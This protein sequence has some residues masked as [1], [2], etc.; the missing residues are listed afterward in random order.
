MAASDSK[1]DKKALVARFDLWRKALLDLTAKNSLINFKTERSIRAIGTSIADFSNALLK[2]PYKYVRFFPV[3]MPDTDTLRRFHLDANPDP[4]EWAEFLGINRSF[5]LPKTASASHLPE[6]LSDVDPDD[7]GSDDNWNGVSSNDM[8]PTGNTGSSKPQFATTSKARKYPDLLAE[9]QDEIAKGEYTDF[10]VLCSAHG[11]DIQ[12]LDRLVL[13]ERERNKNFAF[14]SA[15]DWSRKCKG[16]EG[17]F[18]FSLCAEDFPDNYRN[19]QDTCMLQTALYSSELG[20]KV[21]TLYRKGASAQQETGTQIVHLIVG[22]LEYTDAPQ[23]GKI[24]RAPLIS[25][26]AVISQEKKLGTYIYRFEFSSNSIQSNLSLKEYFDK[27]CGAILPEYEDDEDFNDYLDKIESCAKKIDPRWKVRRFISAGILT[28]TKIMLWKELQATPER[29]EE[30]IISGTPLELCFTPRTESEIGTEQRDYEFDKIPDVLK[31]LPLVDKADSSQE[32]ALF[33]VLENKSNLIIQGPPGTGKSQTITNLLALA[34]ERGMTVLFVAEKLAALQ[35][36]KTR[37][38]Q[39]GL[40]DFCLA[41]HSSGS[42]KTAV[43]HSIIDRVE[44]AEK[45]KLENYRNDINA[46]RKLYISKRDELNAYA[47]FI[48]ELWK[49]SGSTVHS[50]VGSY[51]ET[52][53]KL[54]KEFK[55]DPGISVKADDVTPDLRDEL[56]A[57]TDTFVDIYKSFA[58]SVTSVTSHP[59]YKV[60]GRFF[61]EE[62]DVR[63]AKATLKKWQDLVKQAKTA[64]SNF[65]ARY[66]VDLGG[67]DPKRSEFMKLHESLD[68]FKALPSDYMYSASSFLLRDGNAEKLGKF[69]E[70]Y[71]SVQKPLSKVTEYIGKANARKLLNGELDSIPSYFN[72][73]G[74][75]KP[76]EMTLDELSELRRKLKKTLDE[77]EDAKPFIEAIKK[78]LPDD[79]ASLIT[80]TP[81]GIGFLRRL[82]HDADAIPAKAGL[83][84]LEYAKPAALSSKVKEIEGEI[85]DYEKLQE[86]LGNLYYMREIPAPEEFKQMLS[87]AKQRNSMSLVS[88]MFHREYGKA[89]KSLKS[90]FKSESYCT[91]ENINKLLDYFER[92][93]ALPEKQALVAALKSLKQWHDKLTDDFGS[94][95]DMTRPAADFLSSKANADEFSGIADLKTNERLG[96]IAGLI[97]K[98]GDMVA[99]YDFLGN[100]DELLRDDFS[101]LKQYEKAIGAKVE[102]LETFF[103]KTNAPIQELWDCSDLAS[104]LMEKAREFKQMQTELSQMPGFAEIDPLDPDGSFDAI[105]AYKSTFKGFVAFYNG[106]DDAGRSPEEFGLLQKIHDKESKKELLSSFEKIDKLIRKS[107][108]IFNL[109]QDETGA[110]DAACCDGLASQNERIEACLAVPDN[111]VYDFSRF[112]NQLNL[113]KKEGIRKLIAALIEQHVDPDDWHKIAS[114]EIWKILMDDI[115]SDQRWKFYIQQY[116]SFFANMQGRLK[117][118]EEELIKLHKSLIRHKQY[119]A[120]VSRGRTG[121][122][123]GDKTDMSL[124]NYEMSHKRYM[125]LR[126]II[127][128]AGTALKQ[129]MPCWMMSPLSEA[130]LLPLDFDKFDL[131]VMDEASQIR[132]EDAIGALSRGRQAVIVGDPNQLP[133]TAFF[134][135]ISDESEDSE[136]A[137]VGAGSE[138]IL[139][140]MSA[141]FPVRTLKWHYRSRHESLIQ[142]SNREFYDNKLIVFPSPSTEGGELGIRFHF[143]DDAVYENRTNRKEAEAIARAVIDH[144]LKHP[145]QTLGVVCMNNG[146]TDLVQSCIDKLREQN[147]EWDR[148]VTLLEENSEPL[149]VKN[150]ENVQGDERDVIFISFTYG[151]GE[152]G[153]VM[154]NFGPISKEQGWRRLNVLFTRARMRVE[155]FSSMRAS[156]ITSSGS[157]SSRAL[158]DY[159]HIGDSDGKAGYDAAASRAGRNPDSEFE[160]SVMERIEQAGFKCVP[161]V[162][163]GGFF[164]DIGVCDPEDDSSFILGIECDGRTYHSALTAKDR[165]ILREEVLRNLGW[166]LY[167]IWSTDWFQNSDKIVRN[168]VD[169]LHELAAVSRSRRE[170]REEKNAND[171]ISFPLGNSSQTSNASFEELLDP[172]DDSV[173]DE[174]ESQRSRSPDLDVDELSPRSVASQSV[175]PAMADTTSYATRASTRTSAQSHSSRV[176]KQ[177]KPAAYEKGFHF[178]DDLV[179]ANDAQT[180]YAAPN[181]AENKA[182]QGDNNG[183]GWFG[184]KNLGRES[185]Y[186]RQ[187]EQIRMAFAP[188]QAGVSENADDIKKQTAKNTS[189]PSSSQGWRRSG[190]KASTSVF[191]A[192][193]AIILGSSKDDGSNN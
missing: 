84:R 104:E 144:G 132:P 170:A 15:D 153:R 18:S 94:F 46:E 77:L 12:L 80:L 165:D 154:Q 64:I 58:Q 67:D 166:K 127:A 54:P 149:F 120:E 28:F 70:L 95:Y 105:T 7:E 98:F 63:T 110:N 23:S 40:G 169:K 76:L 167:R 180:D 117:E 158:K 55:S 186:D 183:S 157:K 78:R 129:M 121:A 147:S 152:D 119:N 53:D 69:I 6:V 114:F 36:V 138:S 62:K 163:V 135:H 43:M 190:G 81:S 189:V 30:A 82:V 32:S 74:E 175:A 145:E 47:D 168:I 164:I 118:K 68:V 16:K 50:I 103:I 27:N 31:K 66:G 143:L 148:V 102:K 106:I 136:D 79:V 73:V 178:K 29:D 21:R 19:T 71:E 191:N 33:D 128:Q 5:D 11:W 156:D 72:I 176:R 48:N 115:R 140:Y 109:L 85:D 113:L 179:E 151:K 57:K 4:G 9:V 134:Q 60:A 160:L 1:L 100:A 155:A 184:S 97:D 26:P 99:G 14:S 193:G 20:A 89:K 107:D 38:N 3:P 13:A 141:F 192:S 188:K 177:R 90:L 35:V 185:D 41:L 172:A 25:I 124:I 17:K 123:I 86:E 45:V 161:Q 101:L 34:L 92:K 59:W 125:P 139:D 150:L 122:R 2:K 181:I 87:L 146:Q 131:V 91:D 174:D 22:F 44:H 111:E 112:I 65:S 51:L 42:D 162:G 137:L 52:K 130:E 182:G 96:M 56:L 61:P 173:W 88:A 116:P 24:M 83:L 75:D 159:L 171:A 187:A 37:M 10:R 93:K 8:T 108:E 49:N 133:P 142:F 126:K 39:L